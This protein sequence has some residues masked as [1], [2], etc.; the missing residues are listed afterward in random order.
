MKQSILIKYLKKLIDDNSSENYKVKAEYSTN[1]N[2]KRVVIVQEQPR[3]KQV[4]Y[5]N[6]T[7]LY[8]YYNIE[9]FGLS[10]KECKD[11]SLI[12]GS[13]IG[14]NIIEGDYQLMFIQNIN[15]QFL[16][17]KDIRRVGYTLTL[18]TIINKIKED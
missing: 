9:I 5:G 6:I 16:E 12:I 3:E 11:L 14:Q 8:N 1:D 15:P 17:Y 18:Q 4:F 7:P 10:I 13:L 2:D